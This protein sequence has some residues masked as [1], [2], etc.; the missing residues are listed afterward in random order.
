MKE[1][2]NLDNMQ[3]SILLFEQLKDEV[4]DQEEEFPLIKDQIITLDK[5]GVPVPEEIRNMEKNIPKEWA[6]YLEVLAE[7]EKML[8]YSKVLIREAKK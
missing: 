2:Q 6:S 7:A 3:Y 8:E 4:P 5:Y 1:P